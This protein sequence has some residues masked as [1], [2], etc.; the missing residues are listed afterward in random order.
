[1]KRYALALL[2]L[3]AALTLVLEMTVKAQQSVPGPFCV[4]IGGGVCENGGWRPRS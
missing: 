2:V 4:S 3:I 1:M